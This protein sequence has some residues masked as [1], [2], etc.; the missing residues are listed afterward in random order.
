[1]AVADKLKAL[2]IKADLIADRCVGCM[3]I[4]TA[5]YDSVA[6]LTGKV[7][8]E[9][10]RQ[11]AEELAYRTDG[12]EEVRNRI[13]VSP[14]RVDS[15]PMMKLGYF[16]DS[17]EQYLRHAPLETFFPEYTMDDEIEAELERKLACNCKLDISNIRYHSARQIVHIKGLIA[18]HEDLHSLQ[19]MILCTC[20]VIGICSEVIVRNSGGL[21]GQ[22]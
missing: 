7:D 1:M 3:E 16:P 13:R 18:T 4:G 21:A 9:E 12:I 11:I 22:L 2:R 17:Y 19:D 5:V 6:V 8:T 15:I 20:G 10:Q 14:P